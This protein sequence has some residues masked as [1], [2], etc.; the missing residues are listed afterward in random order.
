MRHELAHVLGGLISGARLAFVEDEG[1][2]WRT[3]HKWPEGL[4]PTELQTMTGYLAAPLLYPAEASG[5]DKF[6]AAVYQHSEPGL[7][8][9]IEIMA[10]E[11]IRPVVE[12]ISDAQ[13][14]EWITK[15]ESGERV[16][17]RATE[18]N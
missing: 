16:F 12:A 3:T 14:D 18:K 15:I 1:K 2:F 4:Q 6:L 11:V 7:F 17:F 5:E 9:E 13:L 8:A 10:R